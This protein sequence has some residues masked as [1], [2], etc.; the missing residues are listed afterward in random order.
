MT[1]K[2]KKYILYY[3]REDDCGGYDICKNG[4]FTPYLGY[5][6]SSGPNA[7]LSKKI[8]DFDNA[9]EL[10]ILLNRSIEEAEERIEDYL[11]SIYG[12]DY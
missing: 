11:Y 3:Y 12:E 7:R 5:N 1:N 8:G 9:E 2:M 6:P 10:A 4:E